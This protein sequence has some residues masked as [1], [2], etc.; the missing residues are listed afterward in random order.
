MQEQT[1]TTQ[2]LLLG[3]DVLLQPLELPG[4]AGVSNKYIGLME[5]VYKF[6]FTQVAV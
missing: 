6:F 2:N 4:D 1:R 3:K 5:L